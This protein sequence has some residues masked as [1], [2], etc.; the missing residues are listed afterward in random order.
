MPLDGTGAWFDECHLGWRRRTPRAP[1]QPTFVLKESPDFE[2]VDRCL[3]WVGSDVRLIRS[4]PTAPLQPVDSFPLI[5]GTPGQRDDMP[6]EGRSVKYTRLPLRGQGATSFHNLEP[7]PQGG[8][9]LP[10]GSVGS[11]P[12]RPARAMPRA[13]QVQP[14]GMLDT[15]LLTFGWEGAGV[16]PAHR[17]A[18]TTRPISHALPES[19][20]SVDT[21]LFGWEAASVSPVRQAATPRRHSES[22]THA[23]IPTTDEAVQ[24][25]WVGTSARPSRTARGGF[26]GV[27]STFA[28]ASSTAMSSTLATSQIATVTTVV[29]IP[30]TGP[31]VF[32]VMQVSFAGVIAGD[33][34]EG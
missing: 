18:R 16:G 14:D 26:A 25:A 24:L 11:V 4:R 31:F 6:W 30:V 29:S 32:E 34:I 1:I 15:F 22:S 27:S 9:E 10:W 19:I 8:A 2:D 28:A 23:L 5:W 20:L 21:G 17:L 12:V 33:I 7:T 3:A 13:T